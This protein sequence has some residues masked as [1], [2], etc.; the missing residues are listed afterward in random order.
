[1]SRKDSLLSVCVAVLALCACSKPAPPPPPTSAPDVAPVPAAA[2]PAPAASEPPAESSLA[3]KR[4]TLSLAS[5]QAT[6]RPCGETAAYWVIDQTDGVLRQT[7]PGGSTPIELYV[8]AHGERTQIPDNVAAARAYPG[9]FILEEVLYATPPAE[10]QG[11]KV[12]PP[13]YIVAARG[14]EPFWAVDVSTD[15]MI[16]R[17]PEDP[18][19][20]VVASPQSQDSEGTVGYTGTGGGHTLELFVDAQPCRDSM[21]GAFFAYS[22]RAVLDGKEFKGCAR[23]GE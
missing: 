22:A 16:W 6:F 1:M 4:G 10:S 19:E 12:P 20:V 9:A 7:F 3:L 15:K 17:Q 21:S 5:E 14:N 2:V 13:T 8:E 23:I 18:Q 11:C